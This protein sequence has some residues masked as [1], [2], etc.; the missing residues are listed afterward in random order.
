MTEEQI[1][2]EYIKTLKIEEESIIDKRCV[3]QKLSFSALK[4]LLISKGQHINEESFD[5]TYSLLNRSGEYNYYAGLLEDNADVSIKVATFKGK[6]K[7]TFLKRQEFGFQCL[8]VAMKNVISYVDSINE[9]YIDTSVR[10]RREKRMFSQEAFIEAW[11]NAVVHNDWK[12]GVP[13]AVYVFDDRLEI[14]SIGGLPKGQTLNSFF[15]GKSVPVNEPM[16]RLFMKLDL[17]EQNGH[18]IPII[19]KEYDKTIFEIEDNFITVTI[20]FDKIGFENVPQK[21]MEEIIINL[22]RNNPNISR[23]EMAEKNRCYYKN[24]TKNNK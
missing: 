20:P 2:R 9:T 21:S 12:Q 22:I 1:E 19:L 23:K 7:T 3:R 8:V 14:V 17:M 18:G 15:K 10:P 4:T 11:T 16:I 6:D 13:P 5:E 24:Y